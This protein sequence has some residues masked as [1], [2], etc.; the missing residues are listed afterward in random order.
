MSVRSRFAPSPTGPLHLG[1]ALSALTAER[2]AR[3]RAGA[4]LLRIEDTDSTRCRPEFEAAILDDLEWLGVRWE[5]PVRRQSDHREAYLR[6]ARTL[7]ARGMLYPCSCTRRRI[8]EAGARPGPE[9]M[10]YPGTCRS[11]PMDDRRPGDALRLDL[12]KALAGAPPLIFAEEGPLHAGEHRVDGADLIDGIGD[13]VL[14]RKDTGDPAYHLAVV[15]DDAVQGI[16]HVVRGDDLWAATPLHRLLQHIMG[17]P[18]PVWH[19][20]G[21]IR[22]ADGKRLAKIDGARALSAYRAAGMTP[23]D[24]KSLIGWSSSRGAP[25]ATEV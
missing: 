19:H 2:I 24:V 9:G 15:H 10:V 14:I 22:D 1:H 25:S 23:Q 21:L 12:A 6:A 17:L 18:V 16:T 20:H 13:P 11:R 4:F 3:D 8:A 7:A 5:G